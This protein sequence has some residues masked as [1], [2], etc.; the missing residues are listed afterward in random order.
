MK[1][2]AIG[3]IAFFA[4][5]GLGLSVAWV[6]LTPSPTLGELDVDA[7][8][9]IVASDPAESAKPDISDTDAEEFVEVFTDD[10]QIGRKKKNKVEVRCFRRRGN[11]VAEIKFYSSKQDGSW[12]TP[13]TF[14]F[15]KKDSPPCD[16]E[17]KDFN[18]D[19]LNDLTYWSDSAF[20]GANERRT[21]FIYDRATDK[22]IHIKNSNEYPNLEY[23]EKLDS[24]TAWHFHRATSTTF[25]R[26]RG[27]ILE[28]FASVSTGD[29]LVANVIDMNGRTRQLSRKKMHFED[30]FTRYSTYDPPRP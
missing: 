21:L 17:I 16:P 27:D 20:R 8:P 6:F 24:L 12:N 26:I 28:E 22:L 2:R 25:L 1:R 11:N 15:I 3:S 4:T 5:M 23:N 18:N 9:K 29:E 30:I 7:E 13:Q 10:S 19:G 14:S